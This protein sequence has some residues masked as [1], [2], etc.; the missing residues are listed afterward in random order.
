MAFAIAFLLVML[1]MSSFIS[2]LTLF[3]MLNLRLIVIEEADHWLNRLII[4]QRKRTDETTDSRV[5]SGTRIL[6]LESLETTLAVLN[7]RMRWL[8]SEDEEFRMVCLPKELGL[9]PSTSGDIK[10]LP[11]RN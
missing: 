3:L 6:G 9:R 4:F 8:T 7:K 5:S 11:I 1:I 2:V 10:T